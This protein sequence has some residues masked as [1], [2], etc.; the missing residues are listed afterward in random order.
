MLAAFG[1]LLAPAAQAEAAKKKIKQPVVTR[2]TPLNASIGDTLTIHG[3]N[4]RRG[5]GTNQV[6]F[7][8]DGAKALFVRADVST[9][10]QMKVVLPPRLGDFLL[11][12]DGAPVPTKFRVRILASR[13]GRAY[14]P[15]SKSPT[16]GPAKPPAP[17]TPPAADAD[18]DCDGDGAKNKVDVDDDNDLLADTYETELKL[19]PCNRDTD[20]DGAEDG[21]EFQSARDLNDDKGTGFVPYPAKRPYANPLVKDDGNDHDGDGLNMGD[22]FKLWVAHGQHV[23]SDG[24]PIGSGS[25]ARVL[26]LSY[27]DGKKFSVDVPTVGYAKQQDFLA[28]AATKGFTQEALLNMNGGTSPMD[29][30]DPSG[31][32]AGDLIVSDVERYY[33]DIN[34]DGKLSDDERDEDA[35]GLSNWIETRG[36]MNPEWWKKIYPK[37]KP[38]PIAYSGT[39][40]A[41]PDSDGDGIR[42]GADDQDRDDLPNVREIRRQLVAGEDAT[43][44]K[45]T[46]GGDVFDIAWNRPS[47]GAPTG[48]PLDDQPMRAWVQPFNPCL[49]NPTSDACEKYPDLSALYPPFHA[50]S[51]RFNVFDGTVVNPE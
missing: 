40:V 32:Y 7:K 48:D 36:F 21:F 12:R 42:D 3:R 8:R 41:D 50:D 2:I 9:L 28:H 44:L 38:F 23:T 24:Q 29:S 22:E 43:G 46:L 15:V 6:V 27:S 10:K 26:V 4:F 16:I 49:P 34:Y 14:T 1:A 39:D 11:V 19:D 30:Y 33:Y 37:E 51:P 35:D 45:F 17:A 25:D 47:E 20:G 5:K 31:P 13:F 18:G